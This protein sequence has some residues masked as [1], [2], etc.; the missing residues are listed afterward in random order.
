MLIDLSSLILEVETLYSKFNHSHIPVVIN[1]LISFIRLIDTHQKSLPYY[2]PLKNGKI[3]VVYFLNLNEQ[4]FEKISEKV[5]E[6]INLIDNAGEE[7]VTP[8]T[9]VMN[10]SVF[11]SLARRLL[12][13]ASE[14]QIYSGNMTK[15]YPFIIVDTSLFKSLLFAYS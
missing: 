1:C 15:K 2:I 9:E 6:L 12:F 11:C 10:Q 3:D 13:V 4:K 14:D 7:D 5:G 8:L